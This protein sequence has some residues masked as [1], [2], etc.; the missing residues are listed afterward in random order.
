MSSY[1]EQLGLN[2]N[3][4][5]CISNNGSVINDTSNGNHVVDYLLNMNDY[6]KFNNLCEKLDVSF[7]ALGENKIFTTNK[8]IG[9]Y[10]THEAY[11]SHTL[12][13]Y[14]PLDKMNA[15]L[16][17]TKFM[18]SAEEKQLSDAISK[19]SSEYYSNYTLVRSTPYFFEVLNKSASKGSSLLLLMNKLGV[20]KQEVMC[21]GDQNN[22]ISM[23]DTAG[24]CIA[25]ENATDELKSRATFIT[26]CNNSDGVAKA[27][28]KYCHL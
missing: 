4:N 25:M 27:I 12:I 15:K 22:D 24:V 1:L 28:E 21:I 26:S 7:H 23:F 2:S 6:E 19:I 10:T 3:N 11:L 8:T 17:F 13:H 14:V 5:Y 16:L 18:I 9:F 20:D